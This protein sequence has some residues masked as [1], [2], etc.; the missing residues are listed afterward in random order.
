MLWRYNLYNP[1]NKGYCENEGMMMNR[2]KFL[3]GLFLV[4]SSLVFIACSSDSDSGSSNA[5][6]DTT[7]AD[8][9]V[10]TRKLVDS[11]IANVDYY[12]DGKEAQQTTSSGEFLCQNPPVQ[13][14]IG[15]LILGK[16]TRFGYSSIVFPQD[17]VGV[18][19]N[20]L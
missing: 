16:I 13:F 9:E 18:S 12:C 20:G 19:R 2:D 3:T 15:K 5:G 17:L 11:P 10:V 6:T 4:L 8:G 1:F 14:Q 7:N